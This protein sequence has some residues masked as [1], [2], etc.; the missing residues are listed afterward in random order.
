VDKQ[1]VLLTIIGVL[2][3]FIAG[4]LFANKINRQEAET[5]RAENPRSQSVQQNPTGQQ[6]QP[7]L[8]AEEIRQTLAKADQNPNDTE[9]QR[10]LGIALYRYTT[11]QRDA[12]YLPDIARLLK[13]AADANPKDYELLVT[14]GNVFFDLGNNGDVKYFREAREWYQKALSIKSD[15]PNVRTDLGLTYYF[16]SPPEPEKA[17]AE[18][19]KSLAIDPKHELT[20]QNLITAL[21]TTKQYE[22]AQ[23]R[24]ETL[25]GINP[26]NKALPDLE[27]HLAQQKVKG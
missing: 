19:R 25:R 4:F 23:K 22:E 13:R 26:K 2:A 17:I 14:L 24:I 5:Q 21:I 3:G 27:A 1:K 16:D 12:T 10:K 8:S 11:S 6:N 18:Y 7:D 20:L 9:F 15:D